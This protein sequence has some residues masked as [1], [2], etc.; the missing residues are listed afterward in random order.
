M[1]AT[2]TA[3][4]TTTFTPLYRVVKTLL[5]ITNDLELTLGTTPIYDTKSTLNAKY[6][7][8]ANATPNAHPTVKYF[9]IGI[10]GSFNV[11]SVNLTQPR[12][13]SSLDMDLYQPL[14]F[15]CVPV[16]QDL[17]ATD[18]AIYRM[19]VIQTVNGQQYAC[20]Y[21]KLM[22]INDAQVQYSQL[23]SAAGAEQPYVIDYTNLN[24]TP[25]TGTT[26]GV[27]TSVDSEVNVLVSTNF[28]VSGLEVI[29]AVNV[30]YAGDMRRAR[31]TEIGVY[32]GTD[33]IVQ[34]TDSTGAAFN[35]TESIMTQL[36]I[37]YCFNGVDMAST[38]ASFN[39][40][41]SFGGSNLILV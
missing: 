22:T 11:D 13:V 5:G 12:D 8:Q 15:R 31:L 21:L 17:S 28:P 38:T 30:L 35:Y 3:T 37:H 39:Q 24:P 26:D 27:S 40:S 36:S 41:F 1:S 25:P 6:G 33:E 20:Y 10:N 7:I 4:P 19:R 2:T 23:S 34:T 32:T 14:P 18:R 29:E 9:G 16:E